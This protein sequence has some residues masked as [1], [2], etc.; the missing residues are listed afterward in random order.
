MRQWSDR[1]AILLTAFRQKR[2]RDLVRIHMLCKIRMLGVIFQL[3]EVKGLGNG[4]EEW[5]GVGIF[6]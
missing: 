1:S 4:E 5:F 6:D 2:L 3:I